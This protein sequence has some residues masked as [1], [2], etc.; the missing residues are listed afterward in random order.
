MVAYIA[1]KTKLIYDEEEGLH[2]DRLG[3][4]DT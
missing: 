4:Q 1:Y 3:L 2:G